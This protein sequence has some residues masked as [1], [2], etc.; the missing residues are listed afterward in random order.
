M[1]PCKKKLEAPRKQTK[2]KEKLRAAYCQQEKPAM[3]TAVG[4]FYG[5]CRRSGPVIL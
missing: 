1:D 5:V 2:P 4:V 3:A